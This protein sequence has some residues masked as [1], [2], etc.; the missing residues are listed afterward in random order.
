M[1]AVD[2][3][4]N[5]LT[6]M[7]SNRRGRRLTHQQSYLDLYYQA[8][9]QI[10]PAFAEIDR[11]IIGDTAQCARVAR[12][13]KQLNDI[14]F[15]W[16][17]LRLD[18]SGYDT[19]EI[20]RITLEEKNQV[21]EIRST[22]R[23]ILKVENLRQLQGEN[24][25]NKT[26]SFMSWSL[27]FGTIILQAIIL[28]LIFLV[29]EELLKRKKAEA[30]LR[31]II[32]KEQQLNELKSRFISMA[33]H[34]FRTPLSSILAST[35]LA[36]K[37]KTTEEQY[38]REK[39]YERIKSGVHNL[40]EILEDMLSIEQLE[41]GKVKV[42][43]VFFDLEEFIE[44]MVEDL[45]SILKPGQRIEY[46]HKGQSKVYLDTSLLKHILINLLSNAVKFSNDND[47]ITLFT[48]LNDRHVEIS[49]KDNGIGISK[50]DQEHLFERFHRGANA[51]N[52]EGTGL[53]LHIVVKYTQL[54]DGNIKCKSE[55]SVGTEF[56]LSFPQ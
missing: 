5:L 35:F 55:E 27:P 51:F 15:F 8:H 31:T 26:I 40:N 50:Q 13:E 28:S 14:S 11:L 9:D 20:N 37:Y 30:G 25:N 36:A 10:I 2:D 22:I 38:K 4:Q 7:E 21:Y 39:H 19:N 45:Q 43:P 53:G 12:L 54:M 6:D 41:I 52:I 49:V 42:R 56:L 29:I 47:I 24:D 16:S 44:A 23:E 3:I 18:E 48:E 32:E 33:S 1:N 46:K 17:S 34:E